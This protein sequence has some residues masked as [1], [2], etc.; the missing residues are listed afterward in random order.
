MSR[1]KMLHKLTCDTL[2]KACDQLGAVVARAHV[3]GDHETID[4]VVPVLASLWQLR[5]ELNITAGEVA[6]ASRDAVA[7]EK[8][9]E[10]GAS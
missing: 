6:G 2:V 8:F 7:R 5:W 4:D 1:A 10:G 3:A 9:D